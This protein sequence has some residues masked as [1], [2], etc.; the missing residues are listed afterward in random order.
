MMRQSN[1]NY[2][3]PENRDF[4]H[5]KLKELVLD[6]ESKKNDLNKDTE[7]RVKV[8]EYLSKKKSPY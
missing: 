5:W 1:N 8:L 6:M 4:V 2:L 3:L 7:T